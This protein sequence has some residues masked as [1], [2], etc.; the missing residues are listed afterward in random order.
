MIW[1]IRWNKEQRKCSVCVHVHRDSYSWSGYWETHVRF[2]TWKN[3]RMTLY[4]LVIPTSHL[5]AI[6]SYQNCHC[7][8]LVSTQVK[9]DCPLRAC[10]FDG[11]VMGPLQAQNPYRACFNGPVTAS[12][13]RPIQVRQNNRSVTGFQTIMSPLI[14]V[15]RG[16]ISGGYIFHLK[17][18]RNLKLKLFCS[19]K[20]FENIIKN[21]FYSEA[22]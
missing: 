2:I 6:L 4:S 22:I 19:K 7:I 14:R 18:P 15:Y 20:N 8:P 21:M 12:Y 1:T 10:Y 9:I 11:P 3:V 5:K 17:K 16:H 13:D